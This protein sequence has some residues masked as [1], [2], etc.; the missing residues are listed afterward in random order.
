MI[1]LQKKKTKAGSLDT[2]ELM[3]L[4][5]RTGSE[6]T[7]DGHKTKWML[8]RKSSKQLP[9]L[10]VQPLLYPM[11]LFFSE[12]AEKYFGKTMNRKTKSQRLLVRSFLKK[13]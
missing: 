12:A 4:P 10:N 9:T 7:E 5:C 11:R 2:L 8:S 1:L 6:G 13:T 3:H